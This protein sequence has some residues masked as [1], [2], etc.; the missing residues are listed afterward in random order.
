MFSF[1][2]SSS[3]ISGFFS[4]FLNQSPERNPAQDPNNSSDFST[5]SDSGGVLAALTAFED[6]VF[7]LIELSSALLQ[8]LSFFTAFVLALAFGISGIENLED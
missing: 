8:T 2:F 3:W 5:F 7:S 6:S 1:T 4:S